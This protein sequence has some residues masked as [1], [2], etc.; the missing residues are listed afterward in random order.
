MPTNLELKIKISNAA[1][2]QKN[3]EKMKAV[4]K[5]TL[6]QKDIYYKFKKGLLKLRVENGQNYLIKYVRD[7]KGKR[8]SDYE[9]LNITGKNVE[10]YLSQILSVDVVVEKKRKLYLYKDTRIHI[11]E[12]KNLGHFLELESVVTSNKKNAAEEFNEVVKLLELDLSGQ[13]KSSYCKLL[14]K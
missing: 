9:I 3:A 12:V 7:E 4:Y 14:K 13:I 10:K 8:W 1:K 6:V 5:G 11:D 2:I